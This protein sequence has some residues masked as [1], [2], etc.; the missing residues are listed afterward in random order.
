MHYSYIT[1]GVINNEVIDSMISKAKRGTSTIQG[2]TNSGTVIDPKIATKLYWCICIPSMLH[3]VE[4]I[5]LS[6]EQTARLE[7]AHRGMSKQLQGLPKATPNA[8]LLAQVGWIS[9]ESYINRK[10]M[11]YLHNVLQLSISS[12]YKE[13]LVVRLVQIQLGRQCSKSPI[14]SIYNKIVFYGLSGIIREMLQ[15]GCVPPEM[16][17]EEWFVMLCHN[18]SYKDTF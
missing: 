15:S 4:C 17:G 8:A 10:S 2:L 5:P 7:R 11:L 6:R 16:S 9:V 12:V 13:L 1:L 14:G 3:A 18:L